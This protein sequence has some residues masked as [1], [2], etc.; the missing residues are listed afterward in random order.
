VKIAGVTLAKVNKS[1]L[2]P[3]N[4]FIA[5][6]CLIVGSYSFGSLSHPKDGI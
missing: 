2:L 5:S 4:I 3:T 1:V 6:H